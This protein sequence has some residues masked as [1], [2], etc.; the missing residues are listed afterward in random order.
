MSL[1]K[2]LVHNQEFCN[3]YVKF[4]E[5]LISSGYAERVPL[6]ELVLSSGKIW[7]ISHHGVYHPQKRKL[8]VVFDCSCKHNNVSLNG[9]LLQGPHLTN[10]LI[11]VLCRFRQE[12]IAF[13]CDIKSMYH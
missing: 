6:K 11:G 13:A 12:P 9:N 10:N 2:K 1:K 8:R 4:M 3:D 5:E 7:Y